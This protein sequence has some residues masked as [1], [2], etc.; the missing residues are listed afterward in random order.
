LSPKIKIGSGFAKHQKTQKSL[1]QV[2]LLPSELPSAPSPTWEPEL[3]A[4]DKMKPFMSGKELFSKR[5]TYRKL[6]PISGLK[7]SA[8][9]EG[10]ITSGY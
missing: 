8:T 9:S 5:L 4:A 2:E 3:C 6:R 10:F 1:T 7:T